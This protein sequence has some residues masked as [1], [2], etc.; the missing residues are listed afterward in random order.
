[1]ATNLNANKQKKLLK[2][3]I[4]AAWID[5]TVQAEEREYL[6]KMAQQ[7]GLANDP[8]IKPLLSELRQ[9]KPQECYD[10]LN[11]YLGENHTQEDYQELLE[12]LS[13]IIYSDGQVDTAEAKLL[14][15]LQEL[16]PAN[17]PPQTVF[18]KFLKSVQLLYRKALEE[19]T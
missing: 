7:E 15:Q 9:V 5:G 1:M 6:H 4:G 19:K 17:D 16:D 14:T 13:A 2:I 18:N 11:A 8:E 12:A 10:W 3:L